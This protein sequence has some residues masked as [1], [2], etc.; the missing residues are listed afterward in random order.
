[1]RMHGLIQSIHNTPPNQVLRCY[2]QHGR[3]TIPVNPSSQTAIEGQPCVSSL[4]AIGG[5]LTD[6]AVSVITPPREW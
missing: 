4:A 2:L 5:D 6:L 3:T 1:M